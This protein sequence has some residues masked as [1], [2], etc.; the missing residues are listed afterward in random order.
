VP[1]AVCSNKKCQLQSPWA[2]SKTFQNP[3][4]NL[5]N[6]Q[7]LVFSHSI[8]YRLLP[9]Y[10]NYDADFIWCRILRNVHQVFIFSNEQTFVFRVFFCEL[11]ATFYDFKLLSVWT[12]VGQF[13]VFRKTLTLD[14]MSKNS[15]SQWV[16]LELAKNRTWWVYMNPNLRGLENFFQGSGQRVR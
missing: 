16:Y 11:Y 9:S 5:S 6:R 15:I 8:I 1:A 13:Q 7:C 14:P 2:F 3:V 10:R 12:S 4:T